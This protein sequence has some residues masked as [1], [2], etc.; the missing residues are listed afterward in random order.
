MKPYNVHIA[1]VSWGYDGKRR[2]VLVISSD[3]KE[4][5]VLTTVHVTLA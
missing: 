1:H 3:E 5:A 4:V 2:P